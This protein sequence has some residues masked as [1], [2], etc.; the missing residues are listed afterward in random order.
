MR[1]HGYCAGTY[2]GRLAFLLLGSWGQSLPFG[3]PL[4]NAPP[5]GLIEDYQCQHSVNVIP[6]EQDEVF[7]FTENRWDC[8]TCQFMIHLTIGMDILALKLG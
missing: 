7:I 4:C 5:S 8:D 1:M 2:F 6:T 3:Q